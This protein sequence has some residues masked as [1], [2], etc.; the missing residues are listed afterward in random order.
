M[1]M[2]CDFCSMNSRYVISRSGF[3]H[4]AFRCERFCVIRLQSMIT[5]FRCVV[6][7]VFLQ[8]CVQEEHGNFVSGGMQT[9][10]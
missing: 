6:F 7:S 5:L 2:R 3:F 8:A 10:E 9:I 4:G 1:Y